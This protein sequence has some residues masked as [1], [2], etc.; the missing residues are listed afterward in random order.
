MIKINSVPS[1]QEC[2]YAFSYK[3]DILEIL[4]SPNKIPV[5]SVYIYSSSPMA[6][7]L[8]NELEASDPAFII[9]A[10][11]TFCAEIQSGCLVSSS[12]Y[13][14]HYL[15]QNNPDA[16]HLQAGWIELSDVKLEGKT[17]EVGPPYSA[18]KSREEL[19]GYCRYLAE[20]GVALVGS[21]QEN[22]RYREL[23]GSTKYTTLFLIAATQVTDLTERNIEKFFQSKGLIT[24]GSAYRKSFKHMA[25]I[26]PQLL[27]DAK[28][29]EF[30]YKEKW[31]EYRLSFTSIPL[32][33]LKYLEYGPFTGPLK[34]ELVEKLALMLKYPHVPAVHDLI[35]MK[36]LM[37][38]YAFL[39]ANNIKPD[40][41]Y[42][43]DKMWRNMST[44]WKKTQVALMKKWSE[45]AS[46]T[47]SVEDLNT[48]KD[49]FM[50]SMNADPEMEYFREDAEAVL[51]VSYSNAILRKDKAVLALGDYA[52]YHAKAEKD[53]YFEGLPSGKGRMPKDIYGAKD[54]DHKKES[55]PSSSGGARTVEEEVKEAER[56][57]ELAYASVF[58]L[59]EVEFSRV[60]GRA[61][62]KYANLLRAA[63]VKKSEII[64]KAKP[65][66]L[67]PFKSSLDP[68]NARSSPDRGEPKTRKP[69]PPAKPAAGG[70][71]VERPTV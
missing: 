69:P 3:V 58:G 60:I 52:A 56:G 24:T 46:S 31:V 45:L 63:G 19:D 21:I 28:I 14:P 25:A 26:L 33:M 17:F 70:T 53:G 32:L 6:M 39:L 44:V 18:F 68:G 15:I 23:L 42:R 71:G 67:R 11:Y 22:E 34:R 41:F 47:D 5:D 49:V 1:G 27:N 13:A 30:G 55:L 62:K 51:K 57:H 54:A 29:R 16:K 36:Y 48:L 64:D 35:G 20:Q 8:L 7:C 4:N 2:K 38:M 50:F 40:K 59:S 37:M 10:G 66:P 61:E 43:C 9:H 65:L 12:A